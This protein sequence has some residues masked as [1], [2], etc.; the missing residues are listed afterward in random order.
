MVET[1]KPKAHLKRKK[2]TDNS[3][4]Q[5]RITYEVINNFP[6]YDPKNAQRIEQQL[7]EIFIKYEKQDA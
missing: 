3:K 5:N 6:E 4:N 1:R 2:K 7:F